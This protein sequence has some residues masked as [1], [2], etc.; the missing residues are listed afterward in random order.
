MKTLL[1]LRHAKSSWKDD[2][3]TDHDRPL[4]ERGKRDA[5]RVGQLL[6]ELGLQPGVVL[7]STAVRARKT[8]K[9]VVKNSGLD[10]A[11]ELL[12]ELYLA[13]PTTYLEI[14]HRQPDAIDC[15][16]IVGHN[17]GIAELLFVLTEHDDDFPTCALMQIEAEISS[18]RELAR[19]CTL[20]DSWRPRELESGD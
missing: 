20:R 9:S 7:S 6:A 10:V 15:L 1:L 2:G 5:P 16:L 3:L 14:V 11:I 19:G 12:P 18:W 4:N 13:D 8:A 17:P